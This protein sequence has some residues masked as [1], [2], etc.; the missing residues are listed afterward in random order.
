MASTSQ[1]KAYLANWFELGKKLIWHDG[2]TLLPKPSVKDGRF[3]PQFEECWQ[4]II[5]IN[6]RGC[7][8]EGSAIAIEELL[9]SS[10]TIDQCARCTMPIPV[11]ESGIQPLACPC[12]DLD[13]WPNL[14]LPVPHGILDSRQQLE[15]IHGRLKNWS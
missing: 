2:K 8:L 15:K 5:G 7:Y 3:T 13:N 14:E 10:W 11:V 12:N 1:V 9:D 4:Q 6:G